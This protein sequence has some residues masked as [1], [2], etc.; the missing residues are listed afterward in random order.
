MRGDLEMSGMV[1]LVGAGPGN[2]GLIT[3]K[4]LEAIKKADCIVY[5]RLASP[6]L[7]KYA[8]EEAELIYVGKLPDR[9]TLTQEEI[10]ELLVEKA[11]EGK[12]V[13]RLKG[14]DPYIFGRGGEEAE[15]LVEEGFRFEVV[16]GITSAIAVPAY[17]GIPVTHRDFNS[18]FSIVTGHERPEKTES[19]IQWD[20]LATATETLVFLM[21][22]SNLPFITQQLIKYGRKPQTPVALIRWGTRIEQR[23]L[24]GT[25]EDIV[26]KVKE[27]NFK[28]PAII[29]VGEV[30]R[31]RDRLSWFEKKPLF[32]RRILVT[33][34][35]SQNSVLLEKVEELGGEPVE[36]PVI[37]TVAPT[38]TTQL[39][40]A[41]QN[42]PAY[43][44]V[45]FTSVNGVNYFFRRLRELKIDV[46]QLSK[47]RIAAIGP[48]TVEAL[49]N[50]GL[51]TEVIPEKYN[52]EALVEQLRPLVQNGEKVLLPRG[53]LAR[54]ILPVELS[55]MGCDVTEIDVY[56]TMMD[57]GNAEEV[58]ELLESGKLHVITFTSSST[59]RNFVQAI[60]TVRD[61]I[62]SLLSQTQIACIGPIT[63]DT[64]MKL[65]LTVDV[66][67]ED[68]TIDGLLKAVQQLPIQ[69]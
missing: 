31:L 32:G 45:I 20:R 11:R 23:T 30:V 12:I 41:L 21:G 68:Y 56:E 50:K 48:K 63:A 49:E 14:G 22:V 4:G 13:T 47:A 44:W 6:R 34:A 7:L 1:Y 53:D 19:S 27:N 2:P 46:R 36:F 28:S 51:V 42:L 38:E 59:V 29:I 5:D 55:K 25:L 57:T 52:A 16:P 35:R 62:H 37:R 58:V 10:N 64:A 33:R 43:D 66:T 61:D 60:R 39:D 65:G 54:E 8:R 26:Q 17:A 3:V 69:K 18:S 15:R 24:V 9:H 67:A 40:Q